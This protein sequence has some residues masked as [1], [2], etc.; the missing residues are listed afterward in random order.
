[1]PRPLK[2]L[3]RV[4]SVLVVL[5]LLFAGAGVW[6]V[7]ASFPQLEGELKVRGLTGKVTVYR[8]KT[9]IP[10]IY[11][12]SPDDLFLAQ[13]YVHAQDRF[14][15]MDF[16]RH[17]TAG[18][19]SEMFGSATLT[20]DRVIRTMGWRKVAEKELPLLDEQTRRYLDAYAGGVNA[21][22]EQHDGFAARSLEY[23]LLRATS[24]DYRPEPWT[25]VDSLTWL[26]AMAWDLRSN[27]T[28]EIGRALAASKLPRGRVEQLWPTYPYDTNQPIVTR[29]SVGERG[30]DQAEEPKKSVTEPPGT[31]A[32]GALIRAAEAI[33]AV[34]SLMGDPAGGS[35]IGSNSW[36]VGGKHTKSGKPLLSNDPHLSPSMPSVWYQA[37]LHCRAKSPECPFD[38]TGFTFSGVPGVIIGHNDRISWGLTNLGPDVADLYLERI[39][40][41]S[42]LFMGDWKPLTTRTETIKVAGGADVQLKV[43]DTMHGP[44]ISDALEST[45]DTLPGMDAAFGEK[46]EA[47]ALKWTALEP[48][49]TADAIFALNTAQDWQQFRAAASKFEVPAQ[50]LIYADTAG[51]IGYQAPGR[52]PVRSHGDGTWPV[53]GWTGEYAWQSTIPFNE[54]PSVYNPPEGYI[55]TANNAVIDPTRYPYI[56]TKD[57]AYGYRSQRILD[58]LREAVK[59]G[60]VDVAAMSALQQDTD[61]GFADFLV[62]K[63][64]DIKIAGPAEDARELLRKWDRSQGED[65]APAMYFNAVWRRLLIETFNDDLPEGAWPGG[66]DRWFEVVRVML[67]KPND[68]FWDDSGTPRTET[69]DDMLRRAMALAYDEL[70]TQLGPDVKDWR[71]GDLHSLKLVHQTFGT[72]GIGPIEWL[73]NRGPFPVAGSDDAVNAAGWDVQF[74]YTV[75]WLPSMRMVVDL[76]NLDESQWI[77]LTG[78]SGHAFHDN[79]WDQASLWAR[80]KTVPMLAHEESIKKA[81]TNVLTL[82]P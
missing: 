23:V 38:V 71:W 80:G 18:R 69:R 77:N 28:D 81:A 20:E 50:N 16:R 44:I 55:V 45:K 64:M 17:V 46:A 60:K 32:A 79:Y 67:D 49:R 3:A 73:F 27:M 52:I 30:F 24:P 21:W 72:S 2:W 34:P 19:L 31:P 42:Y 74:D 4:L 54:L 10:H 66:G 56:L 36:V 75:G 59:D 39:K 7:R 57:W 41:D 62:P 11:A 1:M 63:L 65:S 25:P 33:R 35:G 12:D 5:G 14:F 53:P 47:V 48:G 40:D 9:G 13:G 70:N 68:A 15:E 58:R 6:S 51:N 43:R 37:G 26:K 76:G 8:D 22:M 61:N 78:A 82:N 29:G